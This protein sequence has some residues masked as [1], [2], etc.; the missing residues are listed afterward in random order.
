MEKSYNEKIRGMLIQTMNTDTVDPD[1]AGKLF[2][3]SDGVGIDLLTVDIVRGRDHG[4]APYH[5]YRENCHLSPV[6]TFDDLYPS[7]SKEVSVALIRN[8]CL[9]LFVNILIFRL[10]QSTEY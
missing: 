10:F 5:V 7:I 3:N 9:T 4:L 2:P 8:L 1:Y 6:E